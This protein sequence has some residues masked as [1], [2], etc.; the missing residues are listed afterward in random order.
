MPHCGAALLCNLRIDD[1]PVSR[2]NSSLCVHHGEFGVVIGTVN[3]GATLPGFGR[4]DQR[5]SA[6][7]VSCLQTIHRFSITV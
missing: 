2:R 1:S 7:P 4:V 3:Q 5:Q 6:A